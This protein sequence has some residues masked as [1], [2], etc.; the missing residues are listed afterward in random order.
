MKLLDRYLE[1]DVNFYRKIATVS[2]PIILQSLITMSVNLLDTIMLGQLGET[3]I[4]AAALGNQFINLFHM[5]CMGI[6]MGA[7]VLMARYWGQK[8]MYSLKKTVTIALRVAIV[9]ALIFSV[10]NFLCPELIMKIYTDDADIIA[11]G[12]DYLT[13][14]TATFILVG[15]S[16]VSTQ[17]V[18]S[19]G[20]GKI[21]L[22][23]SIVALFVNLIGNYAFIFG[24]L[25]APELGVVGAAIGTVLARTVECAIIMGMFLIKDTTI[26]YRIK[27]IFK[28]C[29]G[30]VKEFTR[31]AM[32]VVISDGLV[33]LGNTVVTMII[34]RMGAS[35][36]SANSIATVTMTLSCTFLQGLSF[37]GNVI[38]GYTLGEGRPKDAQR[39]GYTFLIVGIV[40][41]I[42]AAGFI[43]LSSN[44]MIS[45]Y[46]VT[47]ETVLITQ[48]LM[49]A[50]ALIV[51]FQAANQMLTKGVLRGGGDTQFLVFADMLFLWI[52][53]IPLG[54]LAG[55][56]W[57]FPAFWVYFFLK[58][59]QVIKALWC[60]FRLN[61]GKWIKKIKNASQT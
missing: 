52:C 54:Y 38:T 56:V 4:S 33:G 15:L 19:V 58:F 53:S 41:G 3:A 28:P 44:L 12:A 42:F 40:V 16:L 20:K 48:E 26:G 11:L 7:T 23:A 24:K 37:S 8:D 46:E 9:L 13:W 17:L 57:G 22:I 14:S 35:F 55:L 47:E 1:K 18:R 10:F 29:G 31:I 49:K 6:G 25:G 34:G 59:D 32:P 60:V 43:M 27:D 51:V 39:Q 45:F 2:I 30:L 61:S 36:I 5:F 21:P 50:I